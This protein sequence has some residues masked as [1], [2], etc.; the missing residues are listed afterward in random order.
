MATYKELVDGNVKCGQFP[1]VTGNAGCGARDFTLLQYP[2]MLDL[3]D[4]KEFIAKC[5]VCGEEMVIEMKTTQGLIIPKDPAEEMA[6]WQKS[7]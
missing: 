6:K 4:H 3:R 5:Q 2:M 1:T 7:N